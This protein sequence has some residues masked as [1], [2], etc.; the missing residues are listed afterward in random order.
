[1]DREQLEDLESVADSTRMSTPRDDPRGAKRRGRK[2]SNNQSFK[3][4][5]RRAIASSK[6]KRES[7]ERP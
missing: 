6:T 3:A 7:R 1:M 2:I 4:R 5:L